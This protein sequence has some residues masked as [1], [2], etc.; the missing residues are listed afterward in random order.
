MKTLKDHPVL[1]D[2]S[3]EQATALEKKEAH[4]LNSVFLFLGIVS[5][6]FACIDFV[7]GQYFSVAFILSW[8]LLFLFLY[9]KERLQA[10]LS[11]QMLSFLQYG[12][13]AGVILTGLLKL[14]YKLG[15]L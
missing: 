13:I 6:A 14:I 7:F 11:S 3:P 9:F 15:G 12:L 10:L 4:Q 5:A 1:S 2:E 8:A